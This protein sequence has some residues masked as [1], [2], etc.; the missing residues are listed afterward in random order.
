MSS[1]PFL[2][3]GQCF[4]RRCGLNRCK[5]FATVKESQQEPTPRG[6][7]KGKVADAW[8]MMTLLD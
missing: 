6:G 8:S 4:E 5:Q 3:F 7:Q 1:P 2:S